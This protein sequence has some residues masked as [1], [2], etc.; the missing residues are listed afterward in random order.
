VDPSNQRITGPLMRKEEEE[1][2]VDI[3]STPEGIPKRGHTVV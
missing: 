3:T 2:V 1:V